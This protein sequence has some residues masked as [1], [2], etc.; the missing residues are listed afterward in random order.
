MEIQGHNIAAWYF[1]SINIVAIAVYGWDKLCAIR[2]RWRVP[3]M[4]LFVIA[5]VGGSIGAIVAMSLFRHKTQH[6]N[7]K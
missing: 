1:A 5:A 7:F 3:E 4:T 6:L 2:K